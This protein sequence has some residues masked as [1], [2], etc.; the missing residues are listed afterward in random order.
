M[1][2]EAHP[3]SKSRLATI[4]AST[5]IDFNALIIERA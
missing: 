5:V 1:R 2:E 4:V 3:V